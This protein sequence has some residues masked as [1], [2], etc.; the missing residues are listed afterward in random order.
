MELVGEKGLKITVSFSKKWSEIYF[1]SNTSKS[2]GSKYLNCFIFWKISIYVEKFYI[3][4]I[5]SPF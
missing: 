1:L 4:Y 3:L 2:S 5:V